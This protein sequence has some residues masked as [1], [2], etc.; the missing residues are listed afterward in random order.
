MALLG[1]GRVGGGG[2]VVAAEPV[3]G[4]LPDVADR[5]VQAEAVGGERLHGGGR[6]VAVRCG[7]APGEVAA[8]DVG[9]ELAVGLELVAP[10]VDRLLDAAAGGVLPFGLGGQAGARPGAVG[11]RVVPGDV[12]D[13]MLGEAV[14]IGS[15]TFGG[16]PGGALDRAPPRRGGHARRVLGEGGVEK[17]VEHEGEAEG[18]GLGL[19]AGGPDEGGE[20]RDGDGRGRDP[21]RRQLDASDRPFGVLR[22]AEAVVGA[23]EEGAAG[24]VEESG[25]GDRAGGRRGGASEAQDLA[26]RGAVRVHGVSLSA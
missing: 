19:V 23:H 22:S 3:G 4:P 9:A 18:L 20:L 1:P 2:A 10:G 21:E 26:A 25:I 12:G 16:P 6:P 24:E 11:Q 13:G 8:P 14:H 17:A 7:V 15:G 5:V